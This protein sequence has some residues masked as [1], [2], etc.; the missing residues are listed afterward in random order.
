[1]SWVPDDLSEE[2]KRLWPDLT[3]NPTSLAVKRFQRSTKRYP[4][5][6]LEILSGLR[7][8]SESS[9]GLML[10][11]AA[12]F[13]SFGALILAMYGAATPGFVF[14]TVPVAL[15]AFL[16]LILF[17]QGAVDLENRRKAA[18]VWLLALE[19]RSV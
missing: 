4:A 6:R 15:L 7:R 11:L 13:V 19:D 2:T 3:A 9:S 1:V 12:F 5:V 10:S 18:I 8:Y 14:I 16:V 17:V